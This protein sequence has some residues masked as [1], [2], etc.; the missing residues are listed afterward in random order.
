MS[1]SLSSTAHIN[2]HISMEQQL[3]LE[4]E[5]LLNKCHAEVI[6]EVFDTSTRTVFVQ[7]R[8]TDWNYYNYFEGELLWDLH[9]IVTVQLKITSP[10]YFRIS[11]VGRNAPMRLTR[12]DAQVGKDRYRMS[13]IWMQLLVYH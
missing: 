5:Q 10:N 2:H 9:S 8:M 7:L 3:R 4:L 11:V 1:T 13:Q 6:Q 12:L